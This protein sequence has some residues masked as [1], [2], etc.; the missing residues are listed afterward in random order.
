MS[1]SEWLSFAALVGLP[2]VGLGLLFVHL[3]RRLLRIRRVMAHGAKAEGVCVDVRDTPSRSDSGT[4]HRHHVFAF[5]TDDGRRIEYVED[6]ASMGTPR[7]YRAI[8][9]Y[10]PADPA[11]TATIA[12]RDDMAPI[13]VPGCAL[14]AT[15]GFLAL[16]L[17]IALTVAL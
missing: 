16:L 2:I 12:G 3:L 15:A 17:W 11:G 10:D 1:G 5:E 7:G 8:V 4:S 13:L 9:R 14:V 6:A